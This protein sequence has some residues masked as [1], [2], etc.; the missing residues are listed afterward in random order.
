MV[1]RQMLCSATWTI[2]TGQ[3][4]WPGPCNIETGCML[5]SATW[6][7]VIG[8]MLWPE[9]WNMVTERMLWLEPWSMETEQMQYSEP[10][11]METG[12][13]KYSEACTME[14]GWKHILVMTMKKEQTDAVSWN[15]DYGDQMMT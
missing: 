2:N 11:A 4:L 8:R 6:T 7:M 14:T 3:I 1:D 10:W 13:M 5:S 12:R 9:L 15:L